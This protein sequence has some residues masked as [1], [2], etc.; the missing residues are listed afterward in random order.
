MYSSGVFVSTRQNFL[1]DKVKVCP[2]LGFCW[3]EAPNPDKTTSAIQTTNG[4]FFNMMI[5]LDKVVPAF[6]RKRIFR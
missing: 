4:I 2:W 6:L 1:P 5:F 3:A